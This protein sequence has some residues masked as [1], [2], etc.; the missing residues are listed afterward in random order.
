MTNKFSIKSSI[1][2][3]IYS[4]KNI[5]FGEEKN[6]ITDLEIFFKENV[7]DV[8]LKAQTNFTFQKVEFNFKNDSYLIKS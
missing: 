1:L 4:F 7:E 5:L 6:N 2:L 8:L 3:L